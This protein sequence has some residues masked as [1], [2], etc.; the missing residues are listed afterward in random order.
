[1][2][3]KLQ[4]PLSPEKTIKHT[5]QSAITDSFYSSQL[6]QPKSQSFVRTSTYV[7]PDQGTVPPLV[8]AQRKQTSV[9]SSIQTI[10]PR[11]PEPLKYSPNRNFA[12]SKSFEENQTEYAVMKY[13][14]PAEPER[15]QENQDDYQH[16]SIRTITRIF[17]P[18]TKPLNLAKPRQ[19]PAPPPLTV[20]TNY[21]RELRSKDDSYSPSSL[22]SSPQFYPNYRSE[23]T[24]ETTR[25]DSRRSLNDLPEQEF[26]L[27][28]TPSKLAMGSIKYD[29]FGNEIPPWSK[30]DGEED[31]PLGAREE[32][33]YYGGTL[34]RSELKKPSK[35]FDYDPQDQDSKPQF[36]RKLPPLV[37]RDEHH[38]VRLE[39]EVTGSP[40][41][42][43]TWFKDGVHVN[44]TPD[45]R[46]TSNQGVYT[47]FI[48]DVY[49]ED[50]GL[51]KVLIK[52]PLGSLESSCQLVV[53]GSF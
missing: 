25:S 46:I 17:E 27:K 19:Q 47:L 48:P 26:L 13:Y 35:I 31:G 14:Q 29:R 4:K 34:K 43:A 40:L 16:K 30:P 10:I 41:P 15:A 6:E 23:Y 24:T 51:Y 5:Q 37:K 9:Q 3:Q 38:S 11:K 36:I 53:E 45:T 8:P 39:L 33:A 7:I 22:Y 49:P 50:S 20:K 28:R 52:N 21:T 2:Y 42:E 44:N 32:P 12:R 1:M 18:N